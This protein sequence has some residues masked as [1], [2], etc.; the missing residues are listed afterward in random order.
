MFKI[1]CKHKWMKWYIFDRT[2]IAT[3]DLDDLNKVDCILICEKCEKIKKI[4]VK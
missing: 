2:E 4:K 3:D 1:F